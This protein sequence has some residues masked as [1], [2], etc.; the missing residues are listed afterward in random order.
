MEDNKREKVILEKI[1]TNVEYKD[2]QEITTYFTHKVNPSTV[3][4]LIVDG[5]ADVEY[6]NVVKKYI[7]KHRK[8][9]SRQQIDFSYEVSRLITGDLKENKPVLVPVR[10]GFGKSTFINTVLFTK[11]LCQIHTNIPMGDLGIIIVTE[12]LEDL[13]SLQERIRDNFGYYNF[14]Q[15][16]DMNGQLIERKIDWM[17]VLQSWNTNISCK[18]HLKSYTESLEKCDR[19]QFRSNCIIGKQSHEQFYS[20]IVGITSERLYYYA[21]SGV[22]YKIAQWKSKGKNGIKLSRKLLLI[23]EKPKLTLVDDISEKLIN[24]LTDA[25]S[26]ID[27]NNS[28]EVRKDKQFM[29]NQLDAIKRNLLNLVEKFEK[30]RNAYVK[31]SQPI[32]TNE[33]FKLWKKYMGYKYKEKIDLIVSFFSKGGLYCRTGKYDLFK[34]VSMA[35]FKVNDFKT[36]IF[37]GTAELS[38]EYDVNDFNLLQVEDFREYSNVTFHLV[39]GNYSK[40]KVLENPEV[41]NPIINWINSHVDQPTY[42]VSYQGASDYLYT[43]LKDNKYVVCYKGSNKQECIPYYGYTKGMNNFKHCTQMIQIGWNRWDSDSYLAYR[44]ATS[45]LIK[46][47]FDEKYEEKFEVIQNLLTNKNGVFAFSDVEMYKL[48]HLINDFEQEVFRTEV[49]EFSNMNPIDI[50]IFGCNKTMKS[51]IAQRFVNCKFVDE[52]WT[53]IEEYNMRKRAH[54]ENNLILKLIDWIRQWDG[55]YQDISNLRNELE[56]TEN[57]WKKIKKKD[58]VKKIWN[59]RKIIVKKYDKKFCI[60]TQEYLKNSMN[61]KGY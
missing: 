38:L 7:T 54:A 36:I 9:F 24:D 34:T 31:L 22:M 56:I 15:Y 50:Y 1:P 45:R 13:L 58:S 18:M 60:V 14:Y 51:M 44:I 42:V 39:E 28:D 35:N 3:D 47:K 11:I 25:V 4:E 48:M 5:T 33:F 8:N 41:V 43:G 21:D 46:N 61:S 53:E 27:E 52:K 57:Y 59:E 12:R 29:K 16:D 32:F 37:D 10:C 40:R 19:C 17:Y 55:N 30:Y 26:K 2:D 49:R 20:P 23:D 6:A